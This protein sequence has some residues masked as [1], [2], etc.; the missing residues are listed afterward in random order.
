MRFSV[1][2]AMAER[3]GAAAAAAEPPRDLPDPAYA[4]LRARERGG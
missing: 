3:L 2:A 4:N 1:A